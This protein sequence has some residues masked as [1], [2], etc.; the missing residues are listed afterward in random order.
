VFLEFS[1]RKHSSCYP[2]SG[3]SPCN[4]KNTS[5][6]IIYF[7]FISFQW[8]WVLD[9]SVSKLCQHCLA[10]Q[11][12]ENA[13]AQHLTLFIS[14]APGYCCHWHF[15]PHQSWQSN[16]TMKCSH[17][18][19]CHHLYALRDIA[20]LVLLQQSIQYLL[21]THMHYLTRPRHKVYWQKL[22]PRTAIKQSAPSLSHSEVTRSNKHNIQICI[23]VTA[24][25]TVT[26][27]CCH[28]RL[29]G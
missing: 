3:W 13:A 9:I 5:N 12:M 21:I 2:L 18:F 26:H 4:R 24:S 8:H 25:T 17:L 11:K 28:T 29:T 20:I 27:M 16:H 10:C 15:H 23:A 7:L 6:F 22:E 19:H 1:S 14:Q